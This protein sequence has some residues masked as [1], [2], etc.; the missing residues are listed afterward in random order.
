MHQVKEIQYNINTTESVKKVNRAAAA[1]SPHTGTLFQ[2]HTFSRAS[3][4]DALYE[5]KAQAA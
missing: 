2:Q 5:S 4:K 1:L 3:T